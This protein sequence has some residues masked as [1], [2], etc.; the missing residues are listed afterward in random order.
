MAGVDENDGGGG[1]AEEMSNRGWK[2]ASL[3]MLACGA[4]FIVDC[5]SS[6]GLRHFWLFG[7][8]ALAHLV[9]D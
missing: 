8:E 1:E 7:A 6:D 4:Y 5:P 2:I 3:V 9:A